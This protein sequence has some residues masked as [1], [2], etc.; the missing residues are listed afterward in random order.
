MHIHCIFA[1][2]PICVSFLESPF[3]W[4]QSSEEEESQLVCGVLRVRL[5]R[6]RQYSFK[7]CASTAVTFLATPPRGGGGEPL[8]LYYIFLRPRV[9][10]LAVG[11]F[12]K[13]F[14]NLRCCF[15]KMCY[16]RLE[17]YS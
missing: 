5:A 6:S 8:Q 16:V 13:V 1:T 2:A 10:E 17:A 14:A 3:L 12:F 15:S 11:L 9:V 7:A 4:T